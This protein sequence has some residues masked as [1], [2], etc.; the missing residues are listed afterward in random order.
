MKKLTHQQK[1]SLVY[2]NKKFKEWNMKSNSKNYNVIT[3]R[4]RTTFRTYK[5]IKNQIDFLDIGCGTG[6][7]SIIINDKKNIVSS[8]GLDYAN[9]MIFQAK[10]NNR[11]LK[12]NVDFIC[13]SF[14]NHNFNKKFNL[15][16]AHGFIEYI[17]Q[18]ELIDFFKILSKITKKNGYI[19]IGSRN[20]LFNIFSSNQFTVM[21]SNEDKKNLINEMIEVNKFTNIENFLKKKLYKTY[22]IFKKHPITG[23]LVKQRN[24]FTPFELSKLIEKFNFK[25]TQIYPVNFHSIMPSLL[26]NKILYRDI[27]E[28]NALNVSNNFQDEFRFLNS[29]SSFIIEAKKI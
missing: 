19:S 7:L 3:D 4:L 2:F 9:N 22:K 25:I 18:K 12:S 29:S 15:I 10:K 23:V 28:K 14:F 13:D 6:Q 16:S 24:Q 11:K 17:S 21:E 5:K 1:T 8:T 26:N 20:R 27:Y